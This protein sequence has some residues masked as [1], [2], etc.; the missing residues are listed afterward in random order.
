A[1]LVYTADVTDTNLFDEEFITAAGLRIGA[2]LAMRLK[3]DRN[4]RAALLQEYKEVLS[5]AM[6]VEA[7]ESNT[8]PNDYDPITAARA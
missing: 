5:S 1:E 2:A 6:A 4:L 7:N 3:K 8:T